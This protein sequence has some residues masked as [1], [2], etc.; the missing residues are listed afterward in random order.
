MLFIQLVDILGYNKIL[1]PASIFFI[2]V[3]REYPELNTV[4]T[5]IELHKILLLLMIV[6]IS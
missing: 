2:P 6:H 4:S 5:T 1:D 3:C